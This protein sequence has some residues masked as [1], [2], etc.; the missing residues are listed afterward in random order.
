VRQNG[1][2]FWGTAHCGARSAKVF[3]AVDLQGPRGRAEWYGLQVLDSEQEADSSTSQNHLAP[4]TGSDFLYKMVLS[5]AARSFST[6]M[7]RVAPEAAG[8]D[9]YQGNRILILSDRAKAETVPSLEILSDDVRCSHGVSIGGLDPEELFYL[10]TRGVSEAESRRVL[11]GGFLETVLARIPDER[12]RQRV[13]LAVEAKMRTME[14]EANE[15]QDT[16]RHEAGPGT[17]GAH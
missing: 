9:G 17:Q 14:A 16:I 4:G 7:V 2:L 12:I 10:R 8:A 15:S 6:G 11:V 3:S 5:G 13:H 1:R